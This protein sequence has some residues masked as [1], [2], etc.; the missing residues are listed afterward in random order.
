[1][2][3][4]EIIEFNNQRLL[5]TEQLAEFYG[6]T[7]IQIQQNIR[8][9]RE[10]FVE[11]KHFYLLEGK[12]LREFK[13]RLENFESVGKNAR[14]LILYTK[15][16]ASRH[17]KMLGTD[18]AWDM[19]DELEENYFNPIPLIPTT[20]RELAQLALAVTEETNQRVDQ[21]EKDI[22]D[23]KENTVI[24]TGDYNYIGSRVNKRV[25]EVAKSFGKITNK[26]RGELYRDING[27][28]K[29]ITGVNARTQL[30]QKHYDA[31]VKFILD[32]EPSTATKTIVRQMSLNLDDI[33]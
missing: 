22:T 27:G 13:N 21:I 8:N 16:G 31:V 30:R 29:K 9:N 26:Q 32:W 3:T 2:N 6:A 15:Q 5:T 25:S 7:T 17:S 28:I 23:L 11:G 20:H 1:M 12:E 33:A 10:K 24:C 19:F 4:P 18:K 14:A